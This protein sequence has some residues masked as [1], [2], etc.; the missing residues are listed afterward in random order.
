[1]VTDVPS[2]VV[3]GDSVAPVEAAPLAQYAYQ[4]LLEGLTSLDIEPGDRITVYSL[5]REFRSRRR[6]FVRH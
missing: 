1:M 3:Q 4:E 5:A 6:R 2:D